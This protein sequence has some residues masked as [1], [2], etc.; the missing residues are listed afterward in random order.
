MPR[1]MTH[2]CNP[3]TEERETEGMLG[4]AVQPDKLNQ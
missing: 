3:S 4:L 2:T 1:L